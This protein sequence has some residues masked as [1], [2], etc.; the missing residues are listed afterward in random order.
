[1]LE[2]SQASPAPPSGQGSVEM[3]TTNDWEGPDILILRLMVNNIIWK[4]KLMSF[5][6]R[7]LIMMN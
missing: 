5:R 7:V 4:D 2:G 3:K 6:A 1:M